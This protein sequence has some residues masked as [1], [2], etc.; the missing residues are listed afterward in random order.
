MPK[1]SLFIIVSALAALAA[2]ACAKAPAG[3]RAHVAEPEPRTWVIVHGAWGCGCHWSDVDELLTA[4]GHRVYRPSLTG[5]GDRVHLASPGIDL[6][7]HIQDI[8]NLLIFERL[9][10]VI[11]VGHSYGG[12]VITGVADRVPER[13]GRL[14]YVD[15]FLPEHGESA[16]DLAGSLAP[17]LDAMTQDGFMVPPW[18]E[19]GRLPPHDVPHPRRTFDQ[20]IALTNE[21]ATRIAATY[22]LTL[23]PGATTDRFS[24]FA[25]R[26]RAR[27]WDVHEMV[28][29]HNPHRSALPDFMRIL[30]AA[31]Q[32]VD[33][34]V[35]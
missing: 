10:N 21:A 11:L 9:E 6:D 30:V 24:P 15:A 7:T 18:V 31:A 22:I 19:A 35:R 32:R 34:T 33:G 28:A 5:L 13:I 16:M 17:Q 23:D 3:A 26:A 1:Y 8:V 20:P 12:M 4:A 14:V 2:P 27:G 29:D 25:D